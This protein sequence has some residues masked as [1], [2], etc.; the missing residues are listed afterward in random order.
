VLLVPRQHFR[1]VPGYLIY[2][3]S[4]P[5][6]IFF[7]TCRRILLSMVTPAV[8]SLFIRTAGFTSILPVLIIFLV[9]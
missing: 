5:G 8:A 1:A 4:I 7:R 9:A 2:A 6:A 3:A